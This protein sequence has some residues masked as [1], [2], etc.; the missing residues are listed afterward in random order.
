MG[1][2]IVMGLIGG[3]FPAIRAIRLQITDSLRQR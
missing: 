3:L 1:L 2:A